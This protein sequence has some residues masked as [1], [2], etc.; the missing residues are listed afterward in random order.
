[1]LLSTHAQPG[2]DLTYGTKQ[3]APRPQ[4][5]RQGHRGGRRFWYGGYMLLVVSCYGRSTDAGGMMLRQEG[6]ARGSR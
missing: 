3:G 4:L 1:M 5:A 6:A 2:T